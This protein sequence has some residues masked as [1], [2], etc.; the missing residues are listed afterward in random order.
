[1]TKILGGSDGRQVRNRVRAALDRE[2]A[3]FGPDAYIRE[4]PE[5]AV[6]GTVDEV[7]DQLRELE[8]AGVERVM[9]QHLVHEDLETVDLLASQ[10]RPGLVG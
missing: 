10:V 9:L 4:N 6:I 1:M 3:D 7:V 2:R 8:G 5:S